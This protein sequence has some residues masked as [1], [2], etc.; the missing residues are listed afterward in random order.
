MGQVCDQGACK[1][2]CP[3]G[4]CATGETCVTAGTAAG[5]CVATACAGVSCPAGK[6][7]KAGACVDACTGAVCPAGETCK[8]GEC[9]DVKS[10]D[11]GADSG[12]KLTI[13]S[14]PDASSANEGGGAPTG[15]GDATVD[16]DASGNEAPWNPTT[17]AGCACTTSPGG[18]GERGAALAFAAALAVTRRRRR[19]R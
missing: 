7:C 16:D 3:C 9:T 14:G 15:T 19:R 18:Y 13:P 1:P 10:A 4:A 12:F 5:Q 17:K 8:A 11:A 2:A 6:A